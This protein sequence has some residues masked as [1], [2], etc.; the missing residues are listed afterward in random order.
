VCESTLPKFIIL[1]LH[2]YY[3][4]YYVMTQAY[5]AS[6]EVLK[7]ALGNIKEVLTQVS[8]EIETMDAPKAKKLELVRSLTINVGSLSGNLTGLYKRGLSAPGGID[9]DLVGDLT[10]VVDETALMVSELQQSLM[11]RKAS[12]VSSSS[13]VGQDF[14]AAVS[15]GLEDISN[16]VANHMA[17]M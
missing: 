17:L 2:T 5:A 6:V 14:V 8:H 4:Y 10:D 13:A 3:Y 1:S 9:A 11:E 16:R 15:N 7:K 12:N